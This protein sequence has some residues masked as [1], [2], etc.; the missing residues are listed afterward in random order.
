MSVYDIGAVVIGRNEGARLA[1]C[2]RSLTGRVRT[3]VYVDSGSDDDSVAIAEALGATVVKLADDTPFTAA[4][5]RNAGFERFELDCPALRFV[6][7]IDG[8]CELCP[9]WIAAASLFLREND[10]VAVACGRRRERF[11][12]ASAYNKLCDIEWDTPVGQAASC[13]GDALMRADAFRGCNGFDERLIAGEEPDLCF[14]LRRNGWTIFRMTDEMTLHDAAMSDFSQ[15][16]QRSRRS[17]YADME[18]CRRRGRAEPHLR[19]KVL[20]N[21]LWAFPA[22][23]PLWPLLWLKISRRKGALYATHIVA[24]KIPH[25]HGILSYWTARLHGRKAA[26][27]EYKRPAQGRVG[28]R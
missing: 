4:R 15:W 14:R 8:D 11:P 18:A 27:I 21:L 1:N 7:F 28:S 23:W 10:A 12:N 19:R 24:G 2:L 3:I 26:L 6:Q 20:S 22:A 13:G 25:V 17:G 5:A 9:D 16:W